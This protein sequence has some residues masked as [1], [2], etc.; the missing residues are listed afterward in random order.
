MEV[1]TNLPWVSW[2]ASGLLLAPCST[3]LFCLP[4]S[5]SQIPLGPEGK[6]HPGMKRRD[7]GHREYE[8]TTAK[9]GSTMEAPPTFHRFMPRDLRPDS[10]SGSNTLGRTMSILSSATDYLSSARMCPLARESPVSVYIRRRGSRPYH[11]T[12][13]S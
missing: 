12:S 1:T 3:H 6:I 2:V 4:K 5:G 11:S 13:L 7:E 10:I 8:A 9:S